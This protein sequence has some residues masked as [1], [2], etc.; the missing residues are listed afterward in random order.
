MR[1]RIWLVVGAALAVIGL[2][3]AGVAILH[4]DFSPRGYIAD[5]FR[6]SPEHDIGDDALAYTTTLAPSQTARKII[7]AWEPAQQYADGSGVYLRYDEDMVVI[8]PFA[9]G[10]LILVER[11]ATAYPRYSDTVG[12][13]WGWGRGVSVRGGG[14]GAGK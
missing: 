10:S 3:V 11:L 7:D 14:P 2:V 13:F 12:G 4:G 1:H 8:R 6:R 5:N 9:L